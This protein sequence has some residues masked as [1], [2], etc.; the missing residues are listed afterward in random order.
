MNCMVDSKVNEKFDLGVEGLKKCKTMI[1]VRPCVNNWLLEFYGFRKPHFYD[2]FLKG[3]KLCC[4][5]LVHVHEVC[6]PKTTTAR[7]H[8][9]L[10]IP[11]S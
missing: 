9:K 1:W 11:T 4:F 5:S 7:L 2:D 8:T 10:T 3:L 6:A